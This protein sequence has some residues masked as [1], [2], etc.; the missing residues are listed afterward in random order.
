MDANSNTPA[1]FTRLKQ[2]RLYQVTLGYAIVAGF[3]IQVGSRAL[4]YFGWDAAVP[5]V[6][7]VLLAGFPVALA[8]AW[9]LIEPQDPARYTGWQKLRWKLGATITAAVSVLVI[10]SGLY[11]W[12]L[13]AQHAQRLAASQ[14]QVVAAAASFNPPANSLVVLPFRNL[15]ADPEQQ[16]FSDGVTEELTSAL[17]QNSALQVIGWKTAS[18]LHNSNLTA[19]DIG[20]QLNVAHI[21][22]GSIL[23]QGEQVRITVELVNTVTEYQLWSFHYDVSFKNIFAVQ[24]QAST[25]I[26]QALQVQFAAVTSPAG[27]TSNPEAHELVLKGRTLFNQQDGASLRQARLYFERAATLDPDYAD[28]HALLSRT[29][30]LLTQRSDLPLQDSL[31]RIRAEAERARTLDPR[32]A[33][34]WVA[35]GNVEANSQPPDFA[36][37]RAAYEQALALDPSDAG[38]HSAYGNVLPLKQAL[39]QA[40]EAA[41]LDPAN[42]DAWN[43]LA[44]DAQD[45]GDWP[46]VVD[47]AGTLIRLDPQNV[48]AAFLLAN[49]YQQLQQYDAMLGAFEQVKPAT[50]LDKRQVTAGRLV[51]QAVRDPK[52]RRPA[53]AAVKVLARHGAN[54]V[55]A[56]NLVQLYL[57]L[58][59]SEPALGAL[60]NLCRASPVACTDAA[61]NPVYR[62]LHGQ[63]RFEQLAAKYSV[64]TPK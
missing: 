14:A 35:L 50:S 55:V 2:H 18:T 26:A 11:V 61:I 58:G 27:G 10:L 64:A 23:R 56:S 48:D 46:Q 34:A 39:A 4:P 63:P 54:P 19:A 25:A 7:I 45:L 32:N 17:G 3:L 31:P 29:L 15:N 9:M 53:L 47:A 37:A 16:Y 49:A 57:A 40:R 60:E 62:A 13:S 52:F 5:A 24:D 1:F 51:Y 20:K 28:A 30:L 36:K 33:G 21:L 43:N 8:L 44:V 59:E 41:L 6:I 42:Q 22:Y 12:K 38:A